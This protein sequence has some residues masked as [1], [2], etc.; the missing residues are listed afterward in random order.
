MKINIYE[1]KDHKIAEAISSSIIINK[2]A[3]ALDL[4]ADPELEESRKIILH[5]EN[6]SPQFFDLRTGLAGEIIQ[7]LVNYQVRW[8]IVGDFENIVSKSLKA[9]IIES[10]RGNVIYFA[11]NLESAKQCFLR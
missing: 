9:F 10:N 3:D 7:K 8:A 4:I 11:K 6:I 2:V 5:K 1:E